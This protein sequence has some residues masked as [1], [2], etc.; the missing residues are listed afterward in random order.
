MQEKSVLNHILGLYE[1]ASSQK[2]YRD[3][4]SLIFSKNTKQAIKSLLL[5]VAG[6]NASTNLDKYS[7]LPS[8]ISRF[9][10]HDLKII[11]EK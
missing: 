6:L 2:L 3:K 1:T 10:L 9:K 5:E 8:L 7:G 4:T 11:L